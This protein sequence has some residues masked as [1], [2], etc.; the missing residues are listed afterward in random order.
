MCRLQ[1]RAGPDRA[2]TLRRISV[3]R[4]RRLKS[5]FDEARDTDSDQL[6]R[7][8]STAENR[9]PC[10]SAPRVGL[11]RRSRAKA[12]HRVWF[13]AR[14]EEHTSELQSQSN[15]VCRLLL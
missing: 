7:D 8:K 12:G 2:E 9:R 4:P 10:K 6:G 11:P 14:S 15:L 13:E 1:N 5:K 3:L